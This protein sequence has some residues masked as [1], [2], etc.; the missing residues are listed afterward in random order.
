M[1]SA[2]NDQGYG[3][4]ALPSSI[5]N[6][7]LSPSVANPTSGPIANP[8]SLAQRRDNEQRTAIK[9]A[10]AEIEELRDGLRYA[11]H[12]LAKSVQEKELA[13]VEL[14]NRGKSLDELSAK[15]RLRDEESVKK[16]Q[17]FRGLEQ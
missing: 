10:T 13:Q 7:N 17:M 15:L 5:S 16:D 9:L 11:E 4:A 1:S 3:V 6:L 12:M 8:Q 14:L 2:T